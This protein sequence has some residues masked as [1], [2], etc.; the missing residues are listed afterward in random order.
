MVAREFTWCK[1]DLAT[2]SGDWFQQFCIFLIS[3]QVNNCNLQQPPLSPP[4]KSLVAKG[5][6]ELFVTGALV[7][8]VLQFIVIHQGN[9]TFSV[10]WSYI[11]FHLFEVLPQTNRFVLTKYLAHCTKKIVEILKGT[12]IFSS[13]L[14]YETIT[15]WTSWSHFEKHNKVCYHQVICSLCVFT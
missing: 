1:E 8:L 4:P 7:T 10:Q 6:Q 2:D 9:S 3:N 15:S 12:L 13:H 5:L 11:C 14:V